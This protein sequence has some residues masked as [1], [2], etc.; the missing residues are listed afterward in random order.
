LTDVVPDSKIAETIRDC[1]QGN[2]PFSE[3]PARL[4]EEALISGTQ[5]N[6]T[7]LIA[8]VLPENCSAYSETVTDLT[9]TG[10]YPV[11]AAQ[12]LSLSMKEF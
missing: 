3:L 12:A 4:V 10:A 5:D 9:C 11:A 1:V 7:V 2:L 8:Q 6:V